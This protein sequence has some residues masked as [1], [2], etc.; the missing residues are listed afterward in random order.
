MKDAYGGSKVDKVNDLICYPAVP[1]SF[2]KDQE[3]PREKEGG[4]K[5]K[6]GERKVGG[7]GGGK[8]R[9]R[10]EGLSPRKERQ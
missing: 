7:G 2:K 6:E 3:F 9:G 8:E 5:E 10:R 4:R 1:K